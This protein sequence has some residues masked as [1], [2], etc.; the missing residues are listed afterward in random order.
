MP[1][2]VCLSTYFKL[3]KFREQMQQTSGI[4]ISKGQEMKEA[5]GFIKLKKKQPWFQ[6]YVRTGYAL[7]PL[8]V[9]YRRVPTP[10]NGPAD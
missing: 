9:D 2:R 4:M 5:G 1:S 8:L 3:Q 10:S 6:I 7:V